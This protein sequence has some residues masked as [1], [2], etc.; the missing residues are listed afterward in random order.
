MI[1]NILTKGSTVTS[2]GYHRVFQT[3]IFPKKYINENFKHRHKVNNLNQSYGN[4][5]NKDKNQ[6]ITG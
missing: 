4:A 2:I 5:Q 3:G 6:V 1:A